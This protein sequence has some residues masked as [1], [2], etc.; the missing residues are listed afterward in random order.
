MFD[1][2]IYTCYSDGDLT[3]EAIRKLILKNGVKLFSVTDHE[4]IDGYIWLKNHMD[5]NYE[6]SIVSGVE[7]EML[8]NDKK[9]HFLV[10]N[11]DVDSAEIKSFFKKIKMHRVLEAV[12]LK[13]K[14]KEVFP[15][16]LLN[17]SESEFSI[18]K[19]INIMIDNKLGETKEDII[20]KYFTENNSLYINEYF[21]PLK[22]TIDLFNRN[23]GFVVLAHPFRTFNSKKQ[24]SNAVRDLKKIGISSV[25]CFHPTN[26]I[27]R[28]TYC[29]ELCKNNNLIVTGGSDFHKGN[30]CAPKIP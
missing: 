5:N 6:V 18:N 3:P 12:E 24:I 29:L 10:Y 14:L 13:R 2:H 21:P 19:I 30:Y 17:I 25:E 28:V 27:Y 9:V 16:L 7:L 1:L 4:N 15:S 22:E 20:N 11:F 26:D 8:F 23:N